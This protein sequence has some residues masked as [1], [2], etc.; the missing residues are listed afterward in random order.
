MLNL[1]TL[2]SLTPPAAGAAAADEVAAG[3]S[4]A[5]EEPQAPSE[6]A[7]ANA[8]IKAVGINLFSQQALQSAPIRRPCT[9]TTGRSG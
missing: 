4:P 3:I 8:T 9:L 6:T 1:P 2:T 7:Q 5:D